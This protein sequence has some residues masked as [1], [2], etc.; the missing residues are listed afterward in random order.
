MKMILDF[1]FGLHQILLCNRGC[2]KFKF[3]N[4]QLNI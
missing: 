1:V 2:N 4:K 3:M